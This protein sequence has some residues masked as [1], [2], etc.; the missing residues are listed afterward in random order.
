MRNPDV[1]AAHVGCVRLGTS[2]V[3]L[4][5]RAKEGEAKME[6]WIRPNQKCV[7]LIFSL[8]F[9]Y[10]SVEIYSADGDSS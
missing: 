9:K 2:Q 4:C 8:K 1:L 7:F 5:L 10:I 3:F 6:G